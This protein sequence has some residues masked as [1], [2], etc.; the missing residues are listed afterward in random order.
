MLLSAPEPDSPLNV[1]V[2]ALI[3]VGDL[4]GAKALVECWTRMDEG[5]YA[6][7]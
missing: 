4:L 2:A 7:P 5:R 3:R 6:G 1:D